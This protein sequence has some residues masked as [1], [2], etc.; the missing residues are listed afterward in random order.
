MIL[1]FVRHGKTPGNLR[2]AYIG[3]T[4]ESLAPEGVEAVRHLQLGRFAPQYWQKLFSSPM[5]RCVET[6]AILCPRQTPLLLDELREADFGMFE[7]KSY[8]ELKE[9][10]EYCRWLDSMG[11][12]SIPE[13]EST[14]AF[15]KRCCDAFEKLADQLVSEPFDQVGFVLHGGVIMAIMERFSAEQKP[16]YHWQ[17]PNAAV[18]SVTLEC[19][20]WNKKRQFSATL[21]RSDKQ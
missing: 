12:G 14:P 11:N 21:F 1:T 9:L 5:K 2:K 4:D 7:G 20:C 3:R 8:E 15:K 6:A 10:P 19:D 13:G 16:F 17:I 18:I